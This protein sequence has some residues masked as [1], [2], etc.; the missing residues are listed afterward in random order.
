MSL[1][2]TLS[3]EA[4]GD[5]DEATDW[6]EQQKPG[7]GSEFVERVHETL[8]AIGATPKAH[9]IRHKRT[10]RASVRVFRYGVFYRVYRDKIVVTAI[11][12]DRRDP[13]TWMQRS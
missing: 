11:V 1:P 2:V 9:Q 3:E 6:H 5:F 12:H 13:S 4:Q 8:T 7:L 10:R